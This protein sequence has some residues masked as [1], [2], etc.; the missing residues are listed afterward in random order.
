MFL[1]HWTKFIWL[2]NLVILFLW[3]NV[4]GKIIPKK[5]TND[6]YTL[7]LKMPNV[8][9]KKHDEYFCTSTNVTDDEIYITRFD[10][11]A[12]STRIHHII[13][14]GCSDLISRSHLYPNSWSC[15]YSPL[16]PG[17]KI[18]YAWGR[19][20]PSLSLPKDVGFHVGHRS[21]IKFLILQAHYASPLAEPDSSGVNLQYTL[22]PMPNVAGI[23]LMASSNA[24]IP[25]HKPKVHVDINCL[26]NREPI[27]VFAF[28]VHAHALGVVISGY[29]YTPITKQFQMLAKGN[30]QW[31]QA[32][33]PLNTIIRV[34]RDEI[35][36]GRCTFNST[37]RETITQIGSTADDEMCNLYLMYYSPNRLF[38]HGY[39]QQFIL[40]QLTS[41]DVC[42]DIQFRERVLILP[43][44]NDEPL[45][46]NISLEESAKGQNSIHHSSNQHPLHRQ[47]S[48]NHNETI[49]LMTNDS[50]PFGMKMFGQIT[51][52]DVDEQ[53][54]IVIFH[55]G[56]HVW[57][58]LSFDKD[59]RF[60]LINKGPIAV[61]TIVTLDP[62]TQHIVDEWGNGLFY[63]PHGLTIDRWNKTVWITDVA[64]HQV[65]KYSIDPNSKNYRKPIIT[66]G[67][68]FVPGNDMEHF[69]KPTSVAIDQNGDFYV[70]D[71]YC[72]GRI[73]R[74]N[75]E[76]KF[77]NHWG[78]PPTYTF[79]PFSNPQ[80]NMFNIP[81]KIVLADT[82]ND[83]LACVADRENGRIQC[84][85]RPYGYFK[86]QI[87]LEQFNGRL[88]S[89]DYD[90]NNRLLYAVAGPSLYDSSRDVLGF[91]FQIETQQLKSI[92]APETGT[93]RQPHDIAVSKTGQM[94][95]VVEIGPNNIWQFSR[96]ILPKIELSENKSFLSSVPSVNQIPSAM[97]SSSKNV[98]K[99]TIIDSNLQTG[100]LN[101]SDST[102][103]YDINFNFELLR[104]RSRQIRNS[105]TTNS[106]LYFILFGLF[107]IIIILHYRYSSPHYS[108]FTFCS[109]MFRFMFTD[110][111][112]T[113][114]R[115]EKINLRSLF[116]DHNQKLKKR[117]FNR[118][119]QN[120]SEI[121]EDNEDDDDEADLSDVLEDFQP[122]NSLSKSRLV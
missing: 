81:H 27:N 11:N 95:Y 26:L 80:P 76:A 44:G 119:P 110:N 92:F 108:L 62:K 10:P 103:Q 113:S 60:Q 24:V 14:F 28:R 22:N 67:E 91:A 33:Y 107:L 53:E 85:N 50:W 105:I 17:M 75:Y 6:F 31:P 43:P 23:Y 78:H 30:P 9:P 18:V 38:N 74:Y 47:Y 84:F 2:I 32:F 39:D 117:G 73:I 83:K 58:E 90:Q 37:Q 5:L 34:E 45:P 25:P 66:L 55:R 94:V 71:G 93:F 48:S 96:S 64:L 36:L 56:N 20:A 99:S 16:C 7:K 114:A 54:R 15:T 35:L 89:I 86:F 19:N 72:N 111:K 42:E 122:K 63:L 41:N 112:P 57:N 88:F 29:K 69:C 3:E 12:D 13:I 104:I 98:I 102:N 68:R 118:V 46:R 65:F 87:Q 106:V 8:H 101:P 1:H 120:E 70:A 109:N 59:E 79:G 97:I 82:D 52:V 100:N 4:N 115:N 21:P 61:S 77:Q 51:A 116:S 121:I 40:G 49:Q